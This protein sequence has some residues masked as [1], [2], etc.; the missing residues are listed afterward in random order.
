[1]KK[2]ICMV[3]VLSLLTF[4]VFAEET[5]VKKEPV[6]IEWNDRPTVE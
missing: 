1:M 6:K 4:G 5:E 2:I 3:L